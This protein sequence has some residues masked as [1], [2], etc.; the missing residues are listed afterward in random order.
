LRNS[1]SRLDEYP[2]NESV[3]LLKVIDSEL[4]RLNP[5]KLFSVFLKI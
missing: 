4:S 2:V 5:N 3:S 1:D